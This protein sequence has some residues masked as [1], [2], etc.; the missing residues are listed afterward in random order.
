[1]K[2]LYKVEVLYEWGPKPKRGWTTVLVEAEGP[3]QAM[4]AGEKAAELS[5]P[6]DRK[7][8]FFE[9]REA[10]TVNLPIVL[11]TIGPL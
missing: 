5:A 2:R 11:Q 8:N 7:W 3:G 10:A 9:A 1:M 6:S 4:E